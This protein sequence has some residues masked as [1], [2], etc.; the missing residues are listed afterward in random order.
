[1]PK[2]KMA[3]SSDEVK[4]IE[5]WIGAGASNTL[6]KDSIKNAPGDSSASNTV[7]EIIFP[8]TDA[9]TVLRMRSAIAPEV[10]KLQKRFPNILDYESRSSADLRLNASILAAKFGDNDLADFGAVAEH[11]TIADF[12]RTS[13][14]DRSAFTIASMKRLRV[15][16]LTNTATTDAT[17][18]RLSALDQL[19]SLNLFGTQVTSAVLPAIS[20]LPKLAHLYAG[21]TSISKESVVSGGLAGKVVF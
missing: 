13:I 20:K 21:Q 18:Q 15:L 19:E 12:S 11:I 16:R 3:L 2:G 6:A 8:E 10:T 7:A 1:M 14:T 5:L 17:L 9:V 4:L